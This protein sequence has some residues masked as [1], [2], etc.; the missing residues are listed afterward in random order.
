NAAIQPRGAGAAA[1]AQ[2]AADVPCSGR[3]QPAVTAAG[4]LKPAPTLAEIERKTP[5]PSAQPSN[6][7]EQRSGC[8]IMPMTL[9]SRLQMPAIDRAEPFGLASLVRR[10][11][12]SQ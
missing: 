1:D 3:L 6:P 9:R 11:S 7:S 10:P 4:R 8:G 2:R 12:E 5:S